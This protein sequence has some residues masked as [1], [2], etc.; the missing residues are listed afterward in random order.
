MAAARGQYHFLGE[1]VC[2]RALCR[3]ARAGVSARQLVS[4]GCFPVPDTRGASTPMRSRLS[5][6]R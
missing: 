4:C 6:T 5:E 3:T 2:R 1:V